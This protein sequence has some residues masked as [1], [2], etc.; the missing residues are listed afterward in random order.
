M[1]DLARRNRRGHG[2][3]DMVL[4]WFDRAANTL[5]E[6]VD[7][8]ILGGTSLQ[9]MLEEEEDLF[10]IKAEVPGLDHKDI[11]IK[12]EDGTLSIKAEWKEESKNGIRSGK[13]QKSYRL[14]GID[15]ENIKATL[16]R[17]ILTLELPK[18]EKSKPK[19]ILIE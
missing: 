18:N 5:F 8:S 6:D 3:D 14:S 2:Y 19:K 1:T 4:N 12:F 15:S 16:D 17:G 9:T 10:L 11:D 7:N 13:V